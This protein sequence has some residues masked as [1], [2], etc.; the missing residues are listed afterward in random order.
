MSSESELPF[1]EP[2][3][4]APAPAQQ[5]EYAPLSA[6]QVRWYWYKAAFSPVGLRSLPVVPHR[7]DLWRYCEADS[8]RLEED[9]RAS[10]AELEREWWDEQAAVARGEWECSD[11]ALPSD[12]SAF[13]T[14]SA[15]ATPAASTA[16]APSPTPVRSGAYEVSLAR[17]LM[18]PCYWP[19][20]AHRVLRG[21]WFAEKA[22][23]EWVPL[24]TALAEQVEGFYRSAVWDPV[25]GRLE[26]FASPPLR[27]ARCELAVSGERPLEALFASSEEAWL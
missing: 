26:S 13:L 25:K 9:Y 4:L 14:A 17:R 27:A 18:S 16:G 2:E 8:L 7:G 11:V 3:L 21:T 19:E 22:A 24:T 23:G 15:T 12:W 10:E 1:G 5:W 20:A 6:D